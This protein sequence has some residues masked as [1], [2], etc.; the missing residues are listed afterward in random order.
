M[1]N[2]ICTPAL[3]AVDQQVQ[4]VA[5]SLNART[6]AAAVSTW[7][8]ATPSGSFAL[9]HVLQRLRPRPPEQC[10]ATE[11]ASSRSVM[12]RGFHQLPQDSSRTCES[13]ARNCS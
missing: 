5:F 9:D 12:W 13:G 11:I 1:A 3:Q 6:G 4:E 8:L 7:W 2:K 10:W